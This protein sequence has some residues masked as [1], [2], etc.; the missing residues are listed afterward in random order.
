MWNQSFY[1]SAFFGTHNEELNKNSNQLEVPGGLGLLSR[2]RH[3]SSSSSVSGDER[4][5]SPFEKKHA[6]DEP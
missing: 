4:C 5:P 6:V 3:L 1:F 2:V